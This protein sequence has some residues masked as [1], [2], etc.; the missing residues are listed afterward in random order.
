MS[1]DCAPELAREG[2]WPSGNG[3]LV[4][5]VYRDKGPTLQEIIVQACRYYLALHEGNK[6]RTARALGISWPRIDRLLQQRP[7]GRQLGDGKL[8]KAYWGETDVLP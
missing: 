8:L 2:F 5:D 4:V 6:T 1:L 7:C 3:T